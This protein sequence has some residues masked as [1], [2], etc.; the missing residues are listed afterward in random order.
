MN[1][2]YLKTEFIE[3]PSNSSIR[4]KLG[5]LVLKIVFVI[6]FNYIS[7]NIANLHNN[8]AHVYIFVNERTNTKVYLN[9]RNDILHFTNINFFLYLIV[10]SSYFS[11]DKVIFV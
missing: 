10:H 6:E 4:G 1:K 3:I 7:P 11:A 8:L 2:G 9:A 5:G